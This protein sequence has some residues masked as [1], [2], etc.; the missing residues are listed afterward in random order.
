M[1]LWIIIIIVVVVSFLGIRYLKAPRHLPAPLGR[2]SKVLGNPTAAE[3]PLDS[4][5]WG[6][7]RRA[8]EELLDYCSSSPELKPVMEEFGA[9]RSTLQKV[10][11]G[12]IQFGAGQWAGGH[13]VAVSALAYPHTLRY[14]LER[15]RADPSLWDRRTDLAKD[16]Q[17]PRDQ[18]AVKLIYHFK[19]EPWEN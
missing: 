3:E 10:H 11:Y 1:E 7:M 17:E 14:I 13:Y 8:E 16:L 2:I 4:P 19:G 12:L 6:K 5:I 9:S 15:Y 18:I